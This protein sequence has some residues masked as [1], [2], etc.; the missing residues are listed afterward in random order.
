MIISDT[1]GAVLTEMLK[2]GSTA[3]AL[4]NS[5]PNAFARVADKIHSSAHGCRFIVQLGGVGRSTGVGPSDVPDPSHAGSVRRLSVDEIRRLVEGHAYAIALLRDCGVDDVQLRA[6]HGHHCLFGFVSPYTKRLADEYGGSPEN[7]ARIVRE[8]VSDT[9]QGGRL[10]D[11]DQDEQHGLPQRWDRL[12]QF[13]RDGDGYLAN[14]RRR[15]R[16]E[17]RHDELLSEK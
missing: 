3:R 10:P 17:W 12:R 2:N 13:P 16:G 8:I 4:Q 15:N 5:Y 11:P 14:G 7:R 9:R 6:A 1:I